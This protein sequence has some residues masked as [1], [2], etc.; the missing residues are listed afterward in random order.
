MISAVSD[1]TITDNEEIFESYRN[2]AGKG[3]LKV[4][5]KMGIST[6]QSYKG[7]QI[8][9]AI[10]LDSSVMSRC[11][12]GTSCWLVFE[13]G[14]GVRAW[15]TPECQLYHFYH[16][17]DSFTSEENYSNT[18]RSD[19]H[20]NITK[21]RTFSNTGTASRLSGAGWEELAADMR[22]F[23]FEAFG[24]VRSS[25][26]VS[27]KPSRSYSV[28][29]S[30]TEISERRSEEISRT[31]SRKRLAGRASK[32]PPALL[33][34]P[35]NYH[36]RNG[37]EIHA[38]APESMHALQNAAR[39]GAYE[40]YKNFARVQDQI[41]EGKT[42]RGC[43]DFRLDESEPIPL[44]QVEPVENIVKRF[45][46]GAMSLGS[47]S[48]E[49][50]ET[51]ALAMNH[52]GGKSNTGEGGEEPRRFTWRGEKG[53]S[54]RSAIKQIASGRFGVTSHYLA[55][56]DQLQ[57]KMAQGAKPGEGGELP[58]HKA[59]GIISETRRTCVRVCSSVCVRAW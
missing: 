5:S 37:G 27:K 36:W 52:L 45:V 7:A 17:Y 13:R 14:V 6:L 21:T 25:P 40:D 8:F 56:A 33:P 31:N 59:V 1:N 44:D 9:E 53:E 10:G 48:Q 29:W 28:S 51:L 4:M 46:T 16:L 19:A 39:T 3:I 11:F 32:A 38:N 49:S 12:N 20:P 26:S 55:N 54:M 24:A 47:I 30:E 57:I 58:G 18:Q 41:N 2:A 34:N 35:G 50:H 42:I 15:F 23:H 22:R 43:L